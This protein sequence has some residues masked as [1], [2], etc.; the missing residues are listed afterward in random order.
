MNSVLKEKIQ[1]LPAL[2]ESAIKLEAIYHDPNSSFDDMV[3]ILEL[4]PLLTADIL[5]A[6][7]SPLYGFTREINS[8]T[9]AVGLFG[10]GTIRGFALAMIVKKSFELD[11]SPYGISNA[12][13]SDLSKT[14][15]ALA[16]TWY[17]RQ[18]P[19][20]MELLSPASFL[21]EI[22][23]VM[24][25][26]YILDEKKEVA[27]L[28]KIKTEKSIKEVELEFCDTYTAAI[29][30]DIFNFWKFDESLI[31]L[32]RLASTP[33]DTQDDTLAEAAKV[34]HVIRVA[35]GLTGVFSEESLNKAKELIKK[36]DLDLASF[37]AAIEKMSA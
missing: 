17:L 11:L 27:F 5:K 36:Y 33:E 14:Q 37:E 22:G 6:A 15:N 4:D 18:K 20:L 28:E 12:Q 21:I 26:Q 8:I 7:N 30:A 1:Q 29:S 9:Q 32:I 23:K 35:A 34:L 2:P 10:M 31:S 16:V 13:F 19:A 25:S 24:I 3:K